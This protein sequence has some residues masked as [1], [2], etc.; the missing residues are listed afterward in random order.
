ME[1]T[2]HNVSPLSKQTI[3]MMYMLALLGATDAQ[4]AQAFGVSVMTIH[5]WKRSHP[6]V[7]D[8]VG[9]GKLVADARVA[10]SLYKSALGYDYE[11]DVVSVYRGEAIVTR[12][13]KHKPANAWAAARWLSL[14]QR[15]LWHEST[16]IDITNRQIHA[17]EMDLSKFSTEELALLEKLGLSQVNRALQEQATDVET[18]NSEDNDKE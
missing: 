18:L 15:A 11:E 3:D 4:M 17:L 16:T 8:A 2:S 13:R 12:V 5:N 9:R 10:E 1:R 14:R 7:V 6:E